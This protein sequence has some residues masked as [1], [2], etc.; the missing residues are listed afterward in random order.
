MSRLVVFIILENDFSHSQAGL[1]SWFFSIFAGIFA[2]KKKTMA[3]PNS[4]WYFP[5]SQKKPCTITKNNRDDLRLSF[6]G[7]GPLW[8]VSYFS[9]SLQTSR[10]VSYIMNDFRNTWQLTCSSEEQLRS[11]CHSDR[12][13][14][15]RVY[16]SGLRVTYSPWGPLWPAPG[17]TTGASVG[18]HRA[19]PQ[20]GPV[21]QGTSLA[22]LHPAPM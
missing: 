2:K 9:G 7:F 22:L 8:L 21:W 5:E 14:F 18:G 13:G 15:V 19:L 17:Y 11:C 1:L 12:F 6:K 20:W 16:V 4:P 10:G 3:R